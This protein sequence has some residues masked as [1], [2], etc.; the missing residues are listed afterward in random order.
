LLDAYQNDPDAGI[1]SAVDW[2][3][4]RWGASKELRALDDKM[5][6]D[7]PRPDRH[8]YVNREG[9][10]FAVFRDVDEPFLMGSPKEEQPLGRDPNDQ[11]QHPVKVGRRFAIATKLITNEQFQRFLRDHPIADRKF[12]SP[13]S[14]EP[15]S[16][17]GP[18]EWFDAARYCQWLSEHQKLP[19]SEWCYPSA[20]EVK[21]DMHFPANYL[22]RTGYRLPTEAEWEFA[23][24]AGAL[25][26]RWYGNAKELLGNYAWFL[27]NSDNHLWPVGLKKPN[28]FGL[29]DVHG[30]AWQWC[31][32]RWPGRHKGPSWPADD[33]A[34]DTAPVALRTNRVLRGGSFASQ[35]IYV[36][37]ASR[38]QE[39]PNF[40][41]DGSAIRVVRTLKETAK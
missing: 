4:S 26:S 22:S 25:T 6:S 10:T 9:I 29:F 13:Y 33:S 16:P 41:A 37:S 19:S 8:W 3:L 27:D 34:E 36:R 2:L 40:V 39:Q 38:D 1:H 31:Q 20:A 14:K 21:E 15:T 12:P 24:R 35:V 28:D 11:D 5:K 18:I 32:E 30:N 23:C 7:E 17:A